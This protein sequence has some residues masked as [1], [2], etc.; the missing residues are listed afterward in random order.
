MKKL[1]LGESVFE[2]LLKPA[3][4]Q[5]WLNG[6]TGKTGQRAKRAKRA[7][8]SQKYL[9]LGSLP[10]GSTKPGPLAPDLYLFLHS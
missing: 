3:H 4:W 5:N 7:N 8:L 10:G 1:N 6:L 2:V 9:M